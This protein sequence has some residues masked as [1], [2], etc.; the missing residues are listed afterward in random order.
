M[1]H[2]VSKKLILTPFIWVFLLG[3]SKPELIVADLTLLLTNTET[4]AVESGTLG[5]GTYKKMNPLT[6]RNTEFELMPDRMVR[7]C[8][9]DTAGGADFSPIRAGLPPS[10]EKCKMLKMDFENENN[11]EV[12]AAFGIRGR[13][14]RAMKEFTLSPGENKIISYPLDE[15]SLIGSSELPFAPSLIALEATGKTKKWSLKIKSL[16]LE[17]NKNWKLE[18]VVDRYGQRKKTSWKGKITDDKIL[19]ESLLSNAKIELNNI[20]AR[21]EFGGIKSK[22]MNASGFFRYEKVEDKWWLVTPGGHLFWSLGVTG[23]RSKNDKT[24]VT[25]VLRREFMFD[26]LPEKDG[27]F[28]SA[29]V[30]N[31][32]FSFYYLN[33]LR[34]Y[35]KI[36]N[37]RTHVFE[38]LNRWGINTIGNWSEDSLL[39]RSEI[40]FTKSFDTKIPGYEEGSGVSDFFHPG[41]V[42]AVDSVCS[43]ALRFKNNKYLLGY[44]VDNEQGWGKGAFSGFLET[45]SDSSQSRKVWVEMLQKKYKT[46]ESLNL[47]LRTTFSS[48]FEIQ[49]LKDRTIF[50]RLKEDI[51]AFET[52]FA[53]QY[54]RVVSSSL[55][56]YD[57]NHLYLGCRFTRQPKPLHIMQTAGKYCDVITV[58]V[59]TFITE[60]LEIW[61]N[62]TRKPIL[63]GEH[64]VPLASER[65]FPPNYKCL[66][67]ED[68]KAFYLNYVE[69]WAKMPFSLGCHWYQF[70]DQH[71]TGRSTNGECQTVGLVDITDQPYSHMIESVNAASLKMYEWHSGTK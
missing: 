15:L 36:D 31:D 25:R 54:F 61:H 52:A 39:Y 17:T 30:G 51:V 12:S 37:W 26:Y 22:K 48:W 20:P 4:I 71:L 32:K 58:N 62:A 19:K 5:G 64:H 42:A 45:L 49:L 55:K 29:W 68:R 41:W 35:G 7:V 70:A 1:K 59:Y 38:R 6:L 67:E 46:V 21:D 9:T 18:P 50:P 47:Q 16:V 44:F 2:F 34:K 33:L 69:R 23:I 27:A 53:A 66:T 14:L 11:F 43:E 65:Q 3:C 40:P 57:P 60:E 10:W 63:I 8:F 56:K 13:W 28:A 24:D